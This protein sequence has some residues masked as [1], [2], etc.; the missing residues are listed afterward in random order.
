MYEISYL[1]TKGFFMKTKPTERRT[2]Q[3]IHK[4]DQLYGTTTIGAR[5]QVVIPA[6]ARKDLGLK[7]GD[8]LVVMGKFQKVLGL[9]KVDQLNEF[10]D[11]IMQNF[12]QTCSQGDL[13]KHLKKTFGKMLKQKN[14]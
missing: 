1:I 10:V 3:N 14:L 12:N 5:G 11:F 13:K 6:N 4:Q 9:I 2:D 7:P 8:Q